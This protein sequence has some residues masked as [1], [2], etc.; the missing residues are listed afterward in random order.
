[1]AREYFR[2]LLPLSLSLLLLTGMEILVAGHTKPP[3]LMQSIPTIAMLYLLLQACLILTS[4]PLLPRSSREW[5]GKS[6]WWMRS[7]AANLLLIPPAML[8][9]AGALSDGLPGLVL[10]SL[11]L[12]GFSAIHHV[13][14][15]RRYR[16]MLKER[17]IAE[18]NELADRLLPSPD[19][20]SFLTCLSD[21]LADGEEGENGPVVRFLTLQDE[22]AGWIVWTTAGEL[23]VGED[24]VPPELAWNEPLPV[25]LPQGPVRGHLWLLTGREDMALFVEGPVPER[26]RQ[27]SREISANFLSLVFR[28]WRTMGFTRQSTE[29][30][31][32]G[33]LLLA[34][35]ADS[36]DDYTHGH[37]LRVAELSIA[38]GREL[39]L[40]PDR[41]QT[42]L[43]GA[44]LHDLGKITIPEDILLKRGLLDSREREVI[45]RHPAE[46]ARIV[47]AME[48]Y[49][50]V[51]RVVLTHHERLDGHGYPSGLSYRE[52]P[53]LGRIVAVADTFD[54]IT[55][56]RSYHTSTDY[57]T[58]LEAIGVGAGT[59]FDA[60]VVAALE[61][62][63]RKRL[64]DD[65]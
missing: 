37:S 40:G 29:S 26:I 52:I 25:T 42:L 8:M 30:F 24:L 51:G 3:S 58:A 64:R 6:R 61:R 22:G 23:T 2:N 11:P 10:M 56:T 38:I 31:L 41:L 60:R 15:R 17:Q 14:A 27:M 1:M 39:G 46:G 19:P 48:G 32:A 54:A 44:L 12:L 45:E 43:V 36:K 4:P 65:D 62:T 50:E 63:I 13:S 35:L 9:M 47:C 28:S 20:H 53:L 16:F 7:A 33:A 59:Q 34:R 5:S 21:Y 18:Q 55:T 57:K 49:G